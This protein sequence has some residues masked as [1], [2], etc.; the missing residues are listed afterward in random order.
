MQVG[1]M[2]SPEEHRSYLQ[3]TQMFSGSSQAE[4][5]HLALRGSRED[6]LGRRSP[7]SESNLSMDS[8]RR[9]LMGFR[10]REN[11]QAHFMLFGGVCA[12]CPLVSAWRP[13]LKAR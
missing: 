13:E 1:C 10:K 6:F 5:L 4:K 8:E 12:S 7:E 11:S 9:D 2:M 3:T